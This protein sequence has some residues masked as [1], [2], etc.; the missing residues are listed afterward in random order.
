MA[1]LAAATAPASLGASKVL[2][3]PLNIA[4]P[5]RSAP[6]TSGPATFKVVALFSKKASSPK[7]KPVAVSQVN[8][9]L[10]KWYG[11]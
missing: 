9:E 8:E 2:G 5:A 6:T 1:S 11:K 3:S 10:A 7:S 4:S